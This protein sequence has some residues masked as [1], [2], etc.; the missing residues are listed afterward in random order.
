MMLG[1]KFWTTFRVVVLRRG[2]DSGYQLL[3]RASFLN[4][5]NLGGGG[6]VLWCGWIFMFF[7]SGDA[8]S[9]PVR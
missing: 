4:S 3:P 7:N 2:F 9:R 5:V 6:I 1:G 8:Y